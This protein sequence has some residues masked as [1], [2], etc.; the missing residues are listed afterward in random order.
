MSPRDST[1]LIALYGSLLPGL[2]AAD[3]LG[4]S[5]ALRFVGPCRIRGTLYDLGDYPGLRE[6]SGTVIGE[7]FEITDRS[8]LSQI[9][10]FEEYREGAPGESVYRRELVDLI[11]PASTRAWL[12]IYNDEA[13]PSRRVSHG[14][15]RRHLAERDATR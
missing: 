2:G 3:E 8:V 13:S 11:E 5:H 6:S 4:V 7:L 12:Y 10:A 15:W 14:D 1:Q 9:D